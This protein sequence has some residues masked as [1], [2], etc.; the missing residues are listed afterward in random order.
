M[1][2]EKDKSCS[3]WL[4]HDPNLIDDLVHGHRAVYALV[5]W[6]NKQQALYLDVTQLNGRAVRQIGWRGFAGWQANIFS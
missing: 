3:Q 4:H 1:N 6:C 5:D 2:P